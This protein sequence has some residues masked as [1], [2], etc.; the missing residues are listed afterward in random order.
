MEASEIFTE[1][2]DTLN[3]TDNVVFTESG[4]A[5][6]ADLEENDFDEKPKHNVV[7]TH[8][9]SDAKNTKNSIEKKSKKPEPIDVS[10][11]DDIF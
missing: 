10:D 4:V 3:M 11:D 8:T 7:K 9:K 1:S 2:K 5:G 6:I